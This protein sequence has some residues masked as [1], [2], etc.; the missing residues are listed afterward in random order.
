MAPGLRLSYWNPRL[1]RT[2]YFQLHQ[3]QQAGLFCDVTLQG[4]GE[5]LNVHS[6][7][8]A[9]CSPYIAKLLTCPELEVAPADVHGV[10]KAA[11]KLQIPELEM[12]KLQGGRLVR[13]ECGRRLNRN[14][15]GS[16][17]HTQ[18]AVADMQND[19]L[20]LVFE[21][22]N[23]KNNKKSSSDMLKMEPRS[24]VK[25]EVEL[26]CRG[27]QEVELSCRGPQEAELSCR[28]PQ[29]AELSCRGPQEVELSCRG[30]QEV[31][32][33]GP[34]E[35]ELSCRGPQGVE[36]SCRVP[37]GVELSC[38]EGI[39]EN[40]PISQSI[41]EKTASSPRSFHYQNRPGTVYEKQNTGSPKM[42]P[43]QEKEIVTV[44]KQTAYDIQSRKGLV[45]RIRLDRGRKDAILPDNKNYKPKVRV[46]DSKNI[47]ITSHHLQ[48]DLQFLERSRGHQLPD[49]TASEGHAQCLE[50]LVDCRLRPEKIKTSHQTEVTDT[51]WCIS[52]EMTEPTEHTETVSFNKCE[53]LEGVRKEWSDLM[54]KMESETVNQKSLLTVG[55]CKSNTGMV[56]PYDITMNEQGKRRLSVNESQA[57]EV[58]KVKLRKV[59]NGRSWEVVREVESPRTECT[60]GREAESQCTDGREAESQCT[61]GREAESQCTDGREAESQCTDGREAESQC[62]DGRE[63]ESQCTDGREAE[64]QCTD[65]REAESQCT[66]GREAES[67]CTDGREAES[68]CTDGRE[69]ES[70]CTDGREAES[71][72]T[73]GREAESQ[74]TDGR[75]AESQC[76][77]G[78]EAE[79]Q[80]T[81]GR[82][83][84]SQCT[85]ER[86]AESQCTDGREAE[87]QC[88][89]GREAESQCTDGRDK[90]FNELEQL[91]EEILNVPSPVSPVVDVGG[92]SPVT[93][94]EG[95]WPDL[96][97]DSD[98]DVDVLG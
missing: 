22:M 70:Q 91:L 21:A 19:G 71:Q 1:M 83:A 7:V 40:E 54:T 17:K 2:V 37:Q 5:G 65:G 80:C 13:P 74:C 10:L 61:D 87:S 39:L 42:F 59:S 25:Q 67:Q 88:T 75:E 73:D 63:A 20:R 6:C 44:E 9:A 93:V 85:D 56:Y 24:Q 90:Q 29:E 11:K 55:Q 36:L 53:G 48:D 14:C 62:T 34:Q 47:N 57:S 31:S 66:D 23:A 16:M 30:P 18:Y 41:A 94:V 8:I 81:D 76:T 89:D 96:S 69:A 43:N 58:E 45:K 27:P 95:V 77:D 52:C 86:E 32:C 51:A 68:Q 50:G 15:L 33:R 72:C 79:S 3:Q 97:S 78:R 46:M 82:E 64:S 49:K 60:D 98:I 4:D 92:C 28:G 38:L 35:V 84:E 26:S 12:L